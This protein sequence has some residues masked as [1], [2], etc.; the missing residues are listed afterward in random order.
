MKTLKNSIAILGAGKVGT[1]VGYLL[2][3]AGH[4]IVAVASRSD[5]SIKRGVEYTGGKAF[6]SYPG[7]AAE[8]ECIIITT[9]DDAIKQVCDDISKS[10]S[11][12]QGKKV[13]HMSGA[14]GLDLLESARKSGAHVASIHPIQTFANVNSAIE[15]IPGS[16]FGITADEEIKEW[17][18]QFVNDL[19]G[20]P[21]FVSEADKP[22]Y[23]AAAC[24]ASNYF[25][26]LMDIVVDVYQTLGLERNEAIQAFWPLVKGTVI[27]IEN[28]GIV[29]ALTGPIARGDIGTVEK[30]LRAFKIRLPELFP[31]Y[32]QLGTL[33][34]DIGHRKKTVSDERARELK[35]LLSGGLKDEQTG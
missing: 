3:S 30:H 23:H 21:F 7:A 26:T 13:V 27:N 11:I 22:L 8:A 25:V 29:E 24:M 15:S 28:H 34:V 12:S 17:A 4:E 10:G 6:K 20:I 5:E 18:V 9:S 19:G 16:T 32:Q 1:A 14:G 35:L 2:R 31:I 33:T